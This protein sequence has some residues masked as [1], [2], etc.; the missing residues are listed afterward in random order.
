MIF[1]VMDSISSVIKGI[2]QGFT[3]FLFIS[4]V[5]VG[6]LVILILKKYSNKIILRK[7]TKGDTDIIIE[8]KFRIITKKGEEE[9]IKLLKKRIELP[10]PPDEALEMTEKGKYYCE[11]YITEDNIVTWINVEAKS[12][13]EKVEVDLPIPEPKKTFKKSIKNAVY[14]VMGDG[15]KISA[16][17]GELN[18]IKQ[19]IQR[20]RVNHI[21]L[22]RLSTKDKA[23]YFNRVRLAKSK[24]SQQNIWAF[25]NQHAGALILV[26]FVFMIFLFW[27]D[28]MK[29]TQAIASSNAQVTGQLTKLVDKMD[30]F[31]NDKQVIAQAKI[32]NTTA[33]T[34]SNS[35]GGGG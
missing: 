32:Y 17:E 23:F 1:Q 10:V 7:K 22:N 25:L 2:M 5:I 30:Q 19:T 24:Y 31:I 11:G 21:K 14:K 35:T 13:K 8:D 3:F 9:Y 26:I 29:P 4:P 28:I 16:Q 33:P 12:I 15:D 20:E 6:A 34:R 27:E 18:G